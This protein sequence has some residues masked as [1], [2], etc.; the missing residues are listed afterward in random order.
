MLPSLLASFD[1]A[2]TAVEAIGRLKLAG[3]S[4]EN[5]EVIS[6]QPHST[7]HF[8]PEKSKCRIGT[9][10]LIGGALGSVSGFL[11]ATLTA[12]AYPLPTGGMPILSWWPIGIVTY[13]TTMLGAVLA[14]L[15]GLLSELKLPNL[16][17]LPAENLVEDGLLIEIRCLE[18]K[19]LA[20][21]PELIA[22]LGGRIIQGGGDP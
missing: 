20:M 3:I 5:L 22:S 15:V 9:F 12:L 21:V 19:D 1:Q 14:T 7:H 2:S 16:K 17:L 10:A 13:E 18:A 4:P 8:L 6:S 11:L